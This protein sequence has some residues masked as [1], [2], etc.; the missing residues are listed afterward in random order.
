LD[1]YEGRSYRGWNHHVSVVLV[2]FAFIV[3]ERV[4]S[5]PPSAGKAAAR[6]SRKRQYGA[7]SGS[8]GTAL[9]GLVHHRPASRR[10]RSGYVA[11]TLPAL[12]STATSAFA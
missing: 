1:H 11:A 12:P 4:R 3:A 6:P 5:F 9:R 7:D 2:C 10:S 8:P